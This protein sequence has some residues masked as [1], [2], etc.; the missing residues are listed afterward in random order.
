M[1]HLMTDLSV[2]EFIT[3]LFVTGVMTA[4][5]VDQVVMDHKS[6]WMSHS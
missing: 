3:K 5:V 1:I 6:K 4:L 2:T